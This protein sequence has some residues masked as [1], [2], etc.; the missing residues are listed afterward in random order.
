MEEIIELIKADPG[1]AIST[2]EL[3]NPKKP[4]TIVEYRKEYLS[5]DRELRDTQ[6]G[7]IQKDRTVN[8]NKVKE[9][10]VPINFAKKIVTTAAAFEVGKP[11]TLIP[12]DDNNLSSLIK[13]IWKVNRLDSL[14]QKLVTLKKKETQGAIQFYINDLQSTSLFNRIVVKLGLK[15]QAKEIKTMLLENEKGLMYPYFDSVGNM[16]LFM[17]KY[18]TIVGDKTIK[19]SSAFTK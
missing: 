6:V 2:I 18:D 10:R 9:V 19:K 13:Q 17:W 16:I 7:V 15:T 8:N 12:S 4:E 5:H 1:K 11:V 3:Q 14:V